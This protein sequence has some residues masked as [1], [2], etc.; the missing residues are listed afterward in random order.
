MIPFCYWM[1]SSWRVGPKL[2][3]KVYRKIYSTSSPTIHLT[4]EGK[5][6]IVSSKKPRSC[7]DQK[8]FNN[9]IKNVPH[10]LICN[11]FTQEF[12]GSTL[13][14]SR[15]NRYSADNI[16]GQCHY[17]TLL[18]WR[19]IPIFIKWKCF[20]FKYEKTDGQPWHRNSGKEKWY[21]DKWEAWPVY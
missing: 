19:N 4:W 21:L 8:D 7:Q 18:F 13:K 1:F 9:E 3:T 5:S 6:F 14:P 16:R 12:D 11:K 17:P 10:D 15:S 2:S 20:H